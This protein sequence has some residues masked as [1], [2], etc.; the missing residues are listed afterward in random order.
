MKILEFFLSSIK[1]NIL[2]VIFVKG[3]VIW[4]MIV[5]IAKI[6]NINTITNL[7]FIDNKFGV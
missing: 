7:E 6:L 4:K 3:Q 1:I 2:N 5:G